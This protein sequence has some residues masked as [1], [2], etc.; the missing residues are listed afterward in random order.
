MGGDPCYYSP[1]KCCAS[2]IFS[3]LHFLLNLVSLYS[4]SFQ[5][6]IPVLIFCR[7]DVVSIVVLYPILQCVHLKVIITI[8]PTRSSTRNISSSNIEYHSKIKIFWWLLTLL[9]NLLDFYQEN[10]VQIDLT[11]VISSKNKFYK[12][13]ICNNWINVEC[14]WYLCSWKIMILF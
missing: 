9:K 4:T 2:T 8:K 14:W 5:F 13:V 11:S 6:K 7:S 10:K 12:T 1:H 3:L